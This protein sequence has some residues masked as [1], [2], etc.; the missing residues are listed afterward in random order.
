[1]QIIYAYS[2][3]VG[4]FISV[5]LY[6]MPTKALGEE[7]SFEQLCSYRG[8]AYINAEGRLA[9]GTARRLREFINSAD[10][11]DCDYA[12][13]LRVSLSSQSGD[14]KAGIELGR[15]FQERRVI[16]EIGKRNREAEC[17]ITAKLEEF[18]LIHCELE[19]ERRVCEGA[20]SLAFLGGVDR[21]RVFSGTPVASQEIL[22]FG[23]VI[24]RARNDPALEVA[25]TEYLKEIGTNL[26]F[27]NLPNPYFPTILQLKEAGVLAEGHVFGRADFNGP[28]AIAQRPSG[29][30]SN[31]NRLEIGC[32][33]RGLSFAFH[34]DRPIRPDIIMGVDV[35]ISWTSGANVY[36]P[37]SSREVANADYSSISFSNGT[38]TV[39]LNPDSIIWQAISGMPQK[40]TFE[41]IG[42]GAIQLD[43]VAMELDKEDARSLR[44]LVSRCA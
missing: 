8:A 36:E 2:C 7:M 11:E 29:S 25:V 6:L 33:E 34:S 43:F 30:S 32:D 10:Y 1:M 28:V 9:A 23:G 22:G 14:A 5:C 19:L 35:R 20:C 41:W 17:A 27:T 44:T 31:F 3:L 13:Q 37:I 39:R 18:D 26:D 42:S 21:N 24:A 40:I 16:V 4:I 12:G 38:S 15:F